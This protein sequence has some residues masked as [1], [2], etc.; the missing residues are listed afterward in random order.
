MTTSFSIFGTV[1]S[2]S[3]Y[4]EFMAVRVVCVV[5][6]R[7]LDTHRFVIHDEG[8]AKACRGA[9]STSFHRCVVDVAA[10]EVVNPKC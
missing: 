10:I 3:E 8:C 1:Q 4:T 9:E 6:G 7:E 2:R 5:D